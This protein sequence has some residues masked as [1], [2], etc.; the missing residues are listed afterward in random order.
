M[1]L[2]VSGL[3]SG[4]DWQSILDKLREVETNKVTMLTNQKTKHNA[5][6]SAWQTFSGKISALQTA[7][8]ELK[9]AEGFNIFTTSV[10]SSSTVA[11]GSLLSAT[12]SSS[13]AKGSYQVVVNNTAQ[14]EKLAS[15]SYQSQTS[16]LNVSGTILVN[17]KAVQ[18]EA[19]DTLQNLRTKINATNSGTSAS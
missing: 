18:V 11:A 10:A 9:K 3:G 12:A 2:S 4:I 8:S 5:K 14:V 13:A 16:A 15:G 7:A 17:G 19:T 1:G 6:L